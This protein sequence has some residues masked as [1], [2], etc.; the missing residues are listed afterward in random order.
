MVNSNMWPNTPSLRHIRLPN[1]SHLEYYLSGSPN[2][3]CH[4][5]IELC[6]YAFL[7]IFKNNMWPNFAP[8]R[9]IRHRNISDLEFDLSRPC[10][11]NFESTIE[12]PIYG[13]L[14]MLNTTI[15][16]N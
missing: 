1:L 16:A 13:F 11:I 6:W 8:I 5:A 9:N 15:V 7:L 2:C 14:F 3:K 10:N 12:L 4:S